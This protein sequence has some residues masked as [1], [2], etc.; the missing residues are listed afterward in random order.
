MF[1]LLSPPLLLLLL[2]L[3]FLLLLL[4]LPGFLWC[5]ESRLKMR[6]SIAAV[7]WRCTRDAR[8][9]VVLESAHDLLDLG[10]GLTSRD[11]CLDAVALRSFEWT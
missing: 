8:P 9:G 6:H 11:G 7:S 4:L 1:L 10:I 3:L 2:L 5:L